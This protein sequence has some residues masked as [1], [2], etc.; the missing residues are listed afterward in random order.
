ML[1]KKLFHIWWYVVTSL[2]KTM[3]STAK[4][5]FWV[6][7][8]MCCSITN[9][10]YPQKQPSEVFY[11][12]GVLWNFTKFTGKHLCQGLFFNKVAGLTPAT[13]FKKRLWHRCFSVIFTKFL[14]TP[15]SQN[16]S[17]RQ[18]LVF[19]VKQFE[20]YIG[21]VFSELW[22]NRSLIFRSSRPEVFCEKGVLRNV[23]KFTGNTC[24]RVSFLIKRLWYR[25]FL[26]NFAK[27]LR[28]PFL[29][30]RLRWVLLNFDAVK[31]F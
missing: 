20:R 4:K 30:E 31:R 13:L 8:W 15:F 24:A 17:K 19:Q 3:K 7:L 14:R 28:T 16:T 22:I 23:A 25:C 11:E 1:L 5:L 27:F 2:V 18:L 29:T 21:V 10:R 9:R 26:G 6:Q 12:K